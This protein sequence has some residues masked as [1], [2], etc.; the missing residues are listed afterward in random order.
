VGADHAEVG[1]CLLAAWRLPDEI[2]EA[3]AHHHRPVTTPV[4]K[5]SA[6]IHVANGLAHLTGSDLGWDGY[7]GLVDA[8]ASQALGITPEKFEE[9]ELEIRDSA[10]QV[11]KFMQIA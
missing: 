4:P 11:E 7:V 6:A 10:S 2:A 3:V 5:L 9:L 1:G 8:E